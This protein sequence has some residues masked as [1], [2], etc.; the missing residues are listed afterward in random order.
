MEVI[1]KN[2][3]L[4]VDDID[5]NRDI[6]KDI[7]EEQ[8]AIYEAENGEE[9]ILQLKKHKDEI[10]LVFLDLLMPKKNGLDVLEFMNETGLI[11]QIPVIM[12]T[13]ESTVDSDVKA[14][15]LGAADIITNDMMEKDI[16]ITFQER[17]S[18]SGR[19]SYPS[20]MCMMHW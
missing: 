18:L 4:I 13:G 10:A 19:R 6:L 8:Y 1:V 5:I 14:Y 20:L 16:R 2:T 11:D 7:F 15:E 3:L 17:I 9:A 12:I